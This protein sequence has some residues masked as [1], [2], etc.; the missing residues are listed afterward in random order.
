MPHA[1]IRAITLNWS[2]VRETS[3]IRALA[4]ATLAVLA[5][6]S[7]ATQAESPDD[8]DFAKRVFGKAPGDRPSSVCFARVYDEAHFATHPDQRTRAMR[9]IVTSRVE[10]GN[11]TYD[12]RLGVAFRNS[13]RKFETS[14]SCGS[15]HGEGDNAG[16]KGV[17]H[18]GVDCDGGGIDVSL[19]DQTAVRVAIPSGARL[20]R[21]G[22]SDEAPTSGRR[23]F[24][25]D[26]KVFHLDRVDFAQCAS[27]I[28]GA[29]DRKQLGKLVALSR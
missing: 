14:G 3:M 29:E 11:R 16:E 23:N 13:S 6:S 26:D 28:H 25:S 12:L 22:S 9:M 7:M 10:E 1:P 20:Y 27:M 8:A 19:R 24:G 4:A 21:A 18:C 17:V 15:I 5:F 2:P